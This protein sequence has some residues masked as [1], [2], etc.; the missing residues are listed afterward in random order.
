M[1]SRKQAGAIFGK[2]SRPV[3]RRTQPGK[4]QTHDH[5]LL[6]SMHTHCSHFAHLLLD[7]TPSDSLTSH[8]YASS[9]FIPLP[10]VRRSTGRDCFPKMAPACF[11]EGTGFLNFL[12]NKLSVHLQRSQCFV[13][14]V[15]TLIMLPWKCGAILSLVSGIEL[16]FILLEYLPPQLAPQIA[17]S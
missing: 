10:G 12:F 9:V 15:G 16:R 7:C 3:E 1:P 8:V 13:L 14:H 4:A 17:I 2:Q 6:F 11:R 5:F